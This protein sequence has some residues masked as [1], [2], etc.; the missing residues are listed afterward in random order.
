MDRS[1]LCSAYERAI[2]FHLGSPTALGVNQDCARREHAAFDQQAEGDA[3]LRG[4]LGHAFH[5][6]FVER[7]GRIDAL[8]RRLHIFG[9]TLD[10][11][12]AAAQAACDGTRRA[13]A[14]EWVEN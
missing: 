5:R 9:L 6:A 13:S 8:A 4:L 14:E 2:G 7:Q 12:P 1:T 10:P 11:D 3:L